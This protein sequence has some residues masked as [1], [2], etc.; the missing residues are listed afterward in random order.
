[1]FLLVGVQYYELY[2]AIKSLPFYSRHFRE[3]K[4]FLE[5][6][7]VLSGRNIVMFWMNI[8]P[9][10]SRL[11]RNQEYVPGFVTASNITT[12]SIVVFVSVNTVLLLLRKT[13]FSEKIKPIFLSEDFLVLL[14]HYCISYT[15][16]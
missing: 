3:F 10:N 12:S 1:V 16:F 6:N 11:K 4:Y 7:F 5:C 14:V 9:P 15:Y 13:S 8:L 2:G